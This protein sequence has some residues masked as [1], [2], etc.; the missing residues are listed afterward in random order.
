MQSHLSDQSLVL[1]ILSHSLR[2]LYKAEAPRNIRVKLLLALDVRSFLF[3]LSIGT[4]DVCVLVPRIFVSQI[5]INF[6]QTEED[7]VCTKY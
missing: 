1:I 2:N 5:F 3:I 7:L 4:C 6:L